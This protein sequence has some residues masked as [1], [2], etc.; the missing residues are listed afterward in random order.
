VLLACVAL[1]VLSAVL[2]GLAPALQ[3]TRTNLAHGLRSA[4][5]DPPGK[6]RMWGRNALVVAQVAMSLMLLTASFL[7]ARS[8]QSSTERATG[9]VKDH[10][11]M[12][13]LDPRLL[14]YDATRTQQFYTQLAERLRSTPGVTGVALTQNPPLGLDTFDRLAFVPDGYELPRDRESVNALM[15]TVDEGYF[16]TFGIALT[17][18]RAFT[19]ADDSHAPL[20]AIV[21]EQFAKHYWPSGD[22]VG[23][24]LRLERRGGTP[25]EIVGVA[26]TIKYADGLERAADFVYLPLAQRPTARMV[27]ML[28]TAGDPLQLVEP[29]KNAVRS[30]DPNMPVIEMRTYDDL[31]RYSTVEGP[32]VAVRMVG[33]MGAVAVFLA[34]AGLYGLVA[35]NVTRRTREIGIRMAIGASSADVLKLVLG[36]GLTLVAVGTAIGLG[37]GFAVEKLFNAML[38]HTSGVDIVS[39]A[40]VV[41]TI[42]LATLLAAYLPARR[43]LRIAPT[44]ALRCE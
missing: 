7:M 27:V 13:R 14:Q 43:A 18:G 12:T 44:Q 29:M 19:A 16:A 8:F 11:L 39:Y 3:S 1:A 6:R 17:H 5:V 33:T 32:R 35:Y 30:L 4:D 24:I 41:P 31:I 34:I 22:A 37:L 28:H 20:V 2:C 36:K 15:D 40:I 38:F 23:R 26:R 21:N 10:M 25:V 42:F 9:F